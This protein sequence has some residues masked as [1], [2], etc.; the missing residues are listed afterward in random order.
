MRIV[1][2]RV[3]EARVTVGGEA[4]GRIGKGLLVFLAV[5]KGDTAHEADRLV[6]KVL[7]LRVFEDSGGKMN[8]CARDVN[9]EFLVVPQ[10]TLYG[11][12]RKGRRPSF[13]A[14]ADPQQGEELYEHFVARLKNSKVTVASGRFRAMMEV[15]LVN[16]GPVTLILD[17]DH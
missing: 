15:A 14:A 5:A 9:A 16:D 2:Q 12:C 11:D 4:V 6:D 3:K 8:L 17:A 10:F 13:D 7:E 1:L